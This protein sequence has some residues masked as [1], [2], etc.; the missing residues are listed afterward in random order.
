MHK[1]CLKCTTF[2]YTNSCMRLGTQPYLSC[3]WQ[4]ILN[5]EKTYL[6]LGIKMKRFNVLNVSDRVTAR[7]EWS[8]LMLMTVNLP[9]LYVSYMSPS[10]CIKSCWLHSNCSSQINVEDL[11]VFPWRHMKHL[12][13][14]VFFSQTQH[15][16]L[17]PSSITRQSGASISH[18]NHYFR[19]NPVAF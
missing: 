7:L 3:L 5:Q 17:P 9:W 11:A 19:P 18:A 8:E 6:L 13:P 2:K 4:Y 12:S 10:V 1:M 15:N 16:H 14:D